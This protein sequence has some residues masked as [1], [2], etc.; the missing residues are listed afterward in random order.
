[1]KTTAM[2]K[3]SY[4]LTCFAVFAFGV[5][6]ARAALEFQA[7]PDAAAS[8]ARFAQALAAGRGYAADLT[9]GTGGTL[10]KGT[11]QTNMARGVYRLHCP[12]AMAPLGDLKVSEISITIRAGSSTRTARMI[13]FPRPDEFIDIPLDFTVSSAKAV[14]ISVGWAIVGQRAKFNRENTAELPS[15]PEATESGTTDTGPEMGEDAG[16]ALADLPKIPYHLAALTPYLEPLCPLNVELS[17][18]KIVYKPGEQGTAVVTLR[19]PGDT[20]QKAQLHVELLSGLQGRSDVATQTLDVPP[21]GE[22][23]WS[24][25]FSL[26]NLYWGAEIRATVSVGISPAYSTGAVF[27]VAKN[28]WETAIVA[29]TNYTYPYRDRDFA[30]KTIEGL[31]KSGYT[32]LESGFWAPDDYLN[33][34]PDKELF[35]GGHLCYKGSL[36][37][38]KNYLEF[39][40]KCGMSAAVYSLTW[41]G[42]G[43][44]VIETMRQHPD[45]F[46]DADFF[47]DWLEDW[48]MME[49]GQI[50]PMAA[51]PT[52]GISSGNDAGFLKRH[53]QEF[54]TS[55]KQIGWDATR[56]DVYTDEDDWVVNA[57]KRVRAMV[58]KEAPEYQWG[59]NAAVSEKISGWHLDN[60]LSGGGLLMNEELRNFSR[61]KSSYAAYMK[62]ALYYRDAVWA[63]NGHLGICYDAPSG[64]SLVPGNAPVATK[65]D[66]LYQN[67]MILAAGGHPFYSSL[68]HEIGRYDQFALR[69]SEFLWNNRMR[70]LKQPD[71][72]VNF[73]GNVELMSWQPLARK[74][75]L[76]DGRHRLVLHLINPPARDASADSTMTTRPPLR[77]VPVT[78]NLPAGATVDGAWAL[79]PQPTMRQEALPTHINGTA[80]SLTVP[81]VRFWTV[82]VV[83]YHGNGI[84]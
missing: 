54:V 53:A 7:V 22:Q 51:W 9:N 18:D 31:R 28:M 50:P 84:E 80:L 16:I 4:L 78:I 73:A 67:I 21:G 75:D 82:V 57:T 58:D 44:S 30:E 33:F 63:H 72:V 3:F 25:P 46:A 5:F 49:R 35:Y 48:P 76:P 38:T 32:A 55:H 2:R 10:I 20:P 24:G 12:L 6:P 66:G 70:L 52:A 1:M 34:N 27:A 36:S 79:T 56:Y 60:M 17:V 13:Y 69:Y 37:G 40:H 26:A 29:G 59:F 81:E 15:D 83:E 64:V 39:A 77:N 8:T 61:G 19:N 71:A 43:P 65:L 11:T 74:L 23:Q 14:P 42:S 41:G 62:E 68:E 47:S 45:W